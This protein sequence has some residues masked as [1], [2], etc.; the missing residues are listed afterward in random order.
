MTFTKLIEILYGSSVGYDSR[1]AAFAVDFVNRSGGTHFLSDPSPSGLDTVRES[2]LTSMRQLLKKEP[3]QR[4]F[5]NANIEGT[6]DLG[7]SASFLMDHLNPA[8]IANVASALGITDPQPRHELV[9][10]AVAAY[11]GGMFDRGETAFLATGKTVNDFY[12]EVL[13]NP[14]AFNGSQATASE[15]ALIV[16]VSN[17]CP[18][19]KGRREL[20]YRPSRDRV[21]RCFRIVDIFDSD[22][23]DDDPR[24]AFRRSLPQAPAFGTDGNRIALCPTH[25][26]LYSEEKDLETC[27]QLFAIKDNLAKRGLAAD[28][29]HEHDLGQKI[30]DLLDFLIE[31]G[32]RR[33]PGAG[34]PDNLSFDSRTLEYKLDNCDSFV[35]ND[36]FLDVVSHFNDIQDYLGDWEKKGFSPSTK[37]AGEIKDISDEMMARGATQ[38]QIVEGITGIIDEQTGHRSK[39]A[40]RVIVSFFIQHCEVLTK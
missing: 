14:D 22:P 30:H 10:Q 38:E 9:A 16:E 18:L 25:A 34:L 1:K 12:V 26:V 5:E 39:P 36:V 29:G 8:K 15:L 21:I 3:G 23:P 32:V 27:R 6:F 2:A 37:L 4:R 31:N 35:F 33:R 11:L 28:L 19:C 40:C 13:A 17:K 20:L 7:G 24:E